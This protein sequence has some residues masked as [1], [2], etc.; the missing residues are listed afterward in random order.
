MNNL[1]EIREIY[2]ATQEQ[3]AEAIG[4]NRVTV[5][6]WELG[7]S[8]ASNTNREK[9]SIYYGIGP[10]Y[11]YEKPL[12]NTVKQMIRNSAKKALEVVSSSAGKR[13]KEADFNKF[14]E[15]MTFTDA[16]DRYMF[17][18][19]LMLATA[20]QGDLDT[21]QTA[22]TINKKMGERLQ[23][24]ISIRQ[25]ETNKGEPSLVELLEKLEIKSNFDGNN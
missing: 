25:D 17:S 1:K 4:V 15:S 5:A 8:V 20:D 22:L 13:N 21:L 11:F 3:I 12:N 7:L 24:I 23:A 6:N 16:M 14:F 10:E 9:L 18:M 19:K 2:G